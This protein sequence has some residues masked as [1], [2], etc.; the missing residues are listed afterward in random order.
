MPLLC[1][2]QRA[3]GCP[4]K[5]IFNQIIPSANLRR[6]HGNADTFDQS[7]SGTSCVVGTRWPTYGSGTSTCQPRLANNSNNYQLLVSLVLIM[8]GRCLNGTA[9]G[10]S[11]EIIPGV[12]ARVS[13]SSDDNVARANMSTTWAVDVSDTLHSCVVGLPYISTVEYGQG[14]YNLRGEV[15]SHK[16]FFSN[17]I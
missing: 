7:S 2:Q 10:Y 4:A 3:F 11:C 1:Q 17:T 12:I 16:I 6:C 5:N 9:V 14:L 13:R 15:T 8:T